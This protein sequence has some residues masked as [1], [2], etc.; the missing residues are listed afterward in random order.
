MSYHFSRQTIR[1]QLD[2]LKKSTFQIELT[3]TAEDDEAIEFCAT[4][5]IDLQNNTGM[6]TINFNYFLEDEDSCFRI[7]NNFS[8]VK[9]I[10]KK[11]IVFYGCQEFNGTHIEAA[12]IFGYK[13]NQMESLKYLD[14]AFQSLRNLTAQRDNFTVFNLTASK[15][16]SGMQCGC[17]L[18]QEDPCEYY[19]RCKLGEYDYY[20]YYY[21]D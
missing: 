13:A 1:C 5:I 6:S 12:W 7:S 8:V 10:S 15:N 2:S 17:D 14:E 11:F 18:N 16:M 20:Y 3:C 9:V 21:D 19:T 4:S